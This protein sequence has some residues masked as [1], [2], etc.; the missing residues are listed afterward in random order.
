MKYVLAAALLVYG[1]TGSFAAGRSERT[2][3]EIQTERF[4]YERIESVAVER[5]N[6]FSV[7]VTGTTGGGGRVEDGLAEGEIIMPENSPF[8]VTHRRYGARLVVTVTGR[9]LFPPA[10]RYEIHLSV[11]PD[12]ATDI[13]VDTG[14]VTLSALGGTTH[15]RTDTGGVT[16]SDCYGEIDT[17]TDTGRQEYSRTAGI[18]NAES[19]TGR[20]VVDDHEGEFHLWTDTGRITGRDILVTGD[21]TVRSDTGEIDLDLLNE[22]DDFTFDIESDTG[23]IAVGEVRGRG[24]VTQGSGPIRIKGKTDTGDVFIR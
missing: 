16:L 13:A 8:T 19:D 11:N 20:I 17:I 4:S 23:V 18:L 5:G 24:D 1:I 21:S 7:F 10:G 12:A 9:S 3:G 2:A 14:E 6:I 22:L 15:V